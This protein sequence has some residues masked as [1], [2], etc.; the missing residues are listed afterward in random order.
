MSS[1]IS[2]YLMVFDV[3]LKVSSRD[4]HDIVDT[5]A[6]LFSSGQPY[7]KINARDSH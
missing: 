5:N 2:T 4:K 6:F 3:E 7:G 1:L